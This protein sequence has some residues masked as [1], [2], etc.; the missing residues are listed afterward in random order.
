M[1]DR[2]VWRDVSVKWLEQKGKRVHI[3]IRQWHFLTSVFAA[4][5]L[6]LED[7]EVCFQFKLV[8]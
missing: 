3:I 6:M 8:L 4:M 2:H 5:S 7:S 1:A